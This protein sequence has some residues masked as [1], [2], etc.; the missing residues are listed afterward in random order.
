MLV[1]SKGELCLMGG[2]FLVQS[3]AWV[4]DTV[5]HIDNQVAYDQNQ[6]AEH[7]DTQDRY[8]IQRGSG[9][10]HERPDA[11]DIKNCLCD[12]HPVK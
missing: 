10:G 2:V 5:K 3:N 6:T 8:H 11:F 9:L 4:Y 12:Y 7:C 1:T